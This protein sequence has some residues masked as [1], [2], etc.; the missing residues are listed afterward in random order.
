[1]RSLLGAYVLYHNR[2][3]N[4]RVYA[5]ILL[6]RKT[7][8]HF[9]SVPVT[10]DEMAFVDKQVQMSDMARAPFIRSKL[11]SLGVLPPK[12]KEKKTP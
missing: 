11:R 3:Q 6:M 8:Q 5:I 7:K 9:L 1:M 4:V 10:A 12:T 2:L